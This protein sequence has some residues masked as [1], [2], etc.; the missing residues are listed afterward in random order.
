VTIDGAA[1]EPEPPLFIAGTVEDTK[2]TPAPSDTLD[3]LVDPGEHLLVAVE[4][5]QSTRER[6]RVE[7][8]GPVNVD[9]RGLGEPPSHALFE[10][11][12]VT[13]G[14]GASGLLTGA[15]FG[16]VAL[17]KR[18]VL[19]ERCPQPASCPTEH[20]GD[21]ATLRR[22]SRAST[23]ALSIGGVVAA[24]GVAMLIFDVSSGP[25]ETEGSS[26]SIGMTPGGFRL[27]F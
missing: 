24:A 10:W 8:G 12:L 19:D 21:I 26:P 20:E 6:M 14:A 23:I 4:N 16:V 27:T 9:L 18:A 13:I 11:S 2:G 22:T 7:P 25:D 17:D 1:L 3:V 15:V 5:G